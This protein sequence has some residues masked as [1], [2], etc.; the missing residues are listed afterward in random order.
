[1]FFS[2][3]SSNKAVMK[4]IYQQPSLEVLEMATDGI[5]CQASGGVDSD[6]INNEGEEEMPVKVDARSASSVEWDDWQ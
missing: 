1:M 3:V 2:Y 4:K 5:L 6:T